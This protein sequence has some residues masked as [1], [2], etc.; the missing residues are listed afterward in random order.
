[1]TFVEFRALADRVLEQPLSEAGFRRT[2]A[3]VWNRR[4]G[5]DLNVVWLQ[6]RS[7]RDLFCVNLGVH[8]SFVPTSRQAAPLDDDVI[9]PP[10]EYQWQFRLTERDGMGDQWWPFVPESANVVAALLSAR[11]LPQFER[12]RVAGPISMMEGKDIEAGRLGILSHI[13]EYGACLFLARMH[14]RLGNIDKCV[15][16]ATIGMRLVPKVASGARRAFRDILER[17]GQTT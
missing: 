1:M 9:E 3:G 13:G 4:N 15:E 14:E 2:K 12:Y 7:S 5:D 8:Y 10:E 17:H 11:G 6:M 16:A